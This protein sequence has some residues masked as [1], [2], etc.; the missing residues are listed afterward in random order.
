MKDKN[1]AYISLIWSIMKVPWS[2]TFPSDDIMDES[3][4][5]GMATRNRQKGGAFTVCPYPPVYREDLGI[6]IRNIC[7]FPFSGFGDIALHCFRIILLGFALF[8]IVL[9]KQSIC[10]PTPVPTKPRQLV[11]RISQDPMEV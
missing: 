9:A 7:S 1:A 10:M 8:D 6:T 2:D 11:T 4:H 3:I 5:G